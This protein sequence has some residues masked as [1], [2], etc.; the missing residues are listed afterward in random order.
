MAA[1]LAELSHMQMSSQDPFLSTADFSE[2]ALLQAQT[3]V[4]LTP[5]ESAIDGTAPE[6]TF[7]LS[8]RCGKYN[9]VQVGT[10]NSACTTD[11]IPWSATEAQVKAALEKLKTIGGGL[12]EHNKHDSG[13]VDVKFT[14]KWD[15]MNRGFIP[16]VKQHQ[17]KKSCVT[18][19]ECAV[20]DVA[21]TEDSSNV[22]VITF[23]SEF[24]DLPPLRPSNA[25]YAHALHVSVETDGKGEWSQRGTKEKKP[26]S[27]RGLCD[28]GTGQCGCV[29][30]YASSDGFG[31]SG[32]RGDCGHSLAYAAGAG[33]GGNF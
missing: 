17:W 8:F 5:G 25:Q 26:C 9:N 15:L 23:K 30:G 16:K 18:V 24:G 14:K 1:Q 28:H 10:I 13:K 12:H 4:V 2:E 19:D 29:D 31:K 32:T 3:N 11:P 21:C 7:R 20:V 6:S 27:G 22:M 33:T